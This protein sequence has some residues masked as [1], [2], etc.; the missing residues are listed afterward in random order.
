M[1]IDKE[2]KV[3]RFIA[4]ADFYTLFILIKKLAEGNTWM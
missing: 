2:S 4:Y 1:P 3:L